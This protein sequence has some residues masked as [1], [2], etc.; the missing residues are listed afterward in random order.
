MIFSETSLS[1]LD[2]ADTILLVGTPD[3]ASI[4]A[5][6][7]ALDAYTKL[8]YP[9]EKIKPVLNAPFPRSS[10]SKEKIETAMG[11]EFLAAFPHVA[12]LVVEA[13]NLGRPLVLD[14]PQ[15]PHCWKILHFSSARRI[16]RASLKIPLKY[17]I[18]FIRGIKTEKSN[19]LRNK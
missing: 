8:G 7:A 2:A 11:M 1:A 10:L 16:K 15:S 5:T 3:M 12:D 13:I 14:K 18:G 17:G 6:A 19:P 4:R 9:V